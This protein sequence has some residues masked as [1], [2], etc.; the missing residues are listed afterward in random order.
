MKRLLTP[1]CSL[2]YVVTVFGQ[3]SDLKL[4]YKQPAGKVWESALPIGNGR[5]AAMVYGNTENETLQ[6]N[7]SSVWTGSPSNNDNPKTLAMLPLI[8]KLTFEGKKDSVAKLINNYMYAQENN[9][10]MFQPV[11]NLNLHFAG[12]DSANVNN[13]RRELDLET[14]IATT[15][16]SIG[17]VTYTRQ[18]FSS[19]PN[20]VIVVRIT[21]NKPSSI[22]FDASA[23]CEQKI[24]TITTKGKDILEW[25]G[26]TGDH[27][28]VKG[29]V[30]FESLIK[31]IT[32][33]GTVNASDK[34]VSVSKANTAT[35]FIS[36]ATNYINYKD[37]S[38]D[39][40]KRA[41]DYLQNAL[42]VAYPK[43]L[44]NHIT[45]FQKYFNRVSFKL[46]ITDEAKNPTD[47][48]L[49]NFNKVND[50]SFA[51][52][53]FQFGRYL[54]ISSSQKGG[55]PAN[56]Q[57]IWNGKL[58]PAWDSKYTININT[59]MNYW[60]AEVTNLTEMHEPLVQMVK[61]L[62]VTGRGTAQTVYG[63]N[64]WVAHH[65]TDLWR[66]TGPVDKCLC[67]IWPMGSA[68]LSQ[69]LWEKYLYSGDKE[70]LATVYPVLKEATRFYFDVL[71]EDPEHHWLVVNPSVSPEQGGISA[72]TTM[73]NQILF[74]LFSGTI[75]AAKALGIDKEFADSIMAIRKRLPPM[76]IGKYSQLQEWTQ[77]LD[78]PKNQHRHVSHLF[79]LFPGKEI[80]P[81][82]TPELFD[83]AR[84][85]LIYRGD[86]GTGWSMAWK[87][88]FWARFLDGNH[89]FT[90]I[91]N[92][93]HPLV[94]KGTM[95]GGGTY[96]N[97][98]DAHPPFQIDGNFGC[99][100]GMAEMLLQSHDGA[101]HLLPALPDSWNDGSISGLRARGGF[102]VVNMEWKDGKLVKAVIKSTLGGNLR[103]RVPNELKSKDGKKL[104][105][106]IG[107]N[108]NV[109]YRV[110][111]VEKPIISSKAVVK[112]VGIKNTILY[113]VATESGKEYV[114]VR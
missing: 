27:E 12:H 95:N 88:N 41:N 67:A 11:G 23:S 62:S 85:S 72:G 1:I 22:S 46:P 99:T 94:D 51:A 112:P 25:S 8:R 47:T 10:M 38:A 7:E 93:L 48:R 105:A 92:Q 58:N 66:I 108:I 114:F 28:G 29:K 106:A 44:S 5:I 3:Q 59:E 18:V 111:Q 4:W 33:G 45:A 15:T 57:G 9:G 35:L 97:L 100:S 52:L 40:V 30:K 54:L 55:Q 21:A 56:L 75:G 65:N 107:E 14:A 74:G 16:Y 82:H 26:I 76:Q 84:T 78:D 24:S 80:S 31:V 61:E 69:H 37:I 13:Y 64:G 2:L 17:G 109:F 102:E 89:A 6:L 42:T 60:P 19:I 83:A 34:T 90:M 110:E 50:P 36:M 39:E 87:V 63:A 81:Y 77:D 101:V 91:K 73:D 68:W 113:D 103:L 96:P 43:L 20:Q 53:Y 104:K 79:G 98:F 86:G 32:E 70:Y 71:Q 49:A